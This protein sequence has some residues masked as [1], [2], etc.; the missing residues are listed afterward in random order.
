MENTANTNLVKKNSIIY[1]YKRKREHGLFPQ[2][3][4]TA[5][6][7]KAPSTDNEHGECQNKQGLSA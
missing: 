6:V 7:N 1:F 5:K 3:L 4:E 2:L